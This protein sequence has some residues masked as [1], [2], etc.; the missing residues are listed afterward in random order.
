MWLLKNGFASE[1]IIVGGVSAGGGL[2]LA[3]LLKLKEL[4]NPIPAAAVT[5]SP[6]TDMTQSG[7]S[8]ITNANLD[9]VISKCLILIAWYFI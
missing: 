6:W 8:M 4:D 1:N 5:M 9:P 2:T 3:L 7:L